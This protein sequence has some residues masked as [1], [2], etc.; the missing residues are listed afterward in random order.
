MSALPRPAAP[1][2]E[3]GAGA[4]P[5]DYG[6]YKGAPAG[7]RLVA[8]KAAPGFPPFNSGGPRISTTLA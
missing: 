8:A 6:D 7:P 1:P 4:S 5:R 2:P 3:L